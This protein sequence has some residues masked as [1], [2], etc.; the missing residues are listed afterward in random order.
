MKGHCISTGWEINRFFQNGTNKIHQV[1][2]YFLESIGQPFLHGYKN[3]M[4]ND[5]VYGDY[6]EFFWDDYVQA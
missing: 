3:S 1:D 6:P 2:V 5:Y 4:R